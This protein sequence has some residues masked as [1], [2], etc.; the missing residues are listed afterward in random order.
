[1]KRYGLKIVRNSGTRSTYLI[2]VGEQ[3]DD[4]AFKGIE[5][6]HRI[7]KSPR[8]REPEIL[9]GEGGGKFF[10]PLAEWPQLRELITGILNGTAQE[11]QPRQLWLAPDWQELAA[12]NY[13]DIWIDFSRHA[14]GQ[15]V[16]VDEQGAETI[17][18][19]LGEIAVHTYVFP[20][21][22]LSTSP[23]PGD[24]FRFAGRE[25]QVSEAVIDDFLSQCRARAVDL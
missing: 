11:I 17:W 2:A 1:M 9:L 5:I 8:Q 4:D 10:I 21:L 3:A 14:P 13:R 7:I 12:P 18:D 25:M 16:F 23:Q 24:H 6:A 15:L 22:G 20:Q 19:G